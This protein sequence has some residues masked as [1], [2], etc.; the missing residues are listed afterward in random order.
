MN[1]G[2]NIECIIGTSIM[3]KNKEMVFELVNYIVLYK[4]KGNSSNSF[5]TIYKKKLK[6]L[7][8]LL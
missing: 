7:R 5:E 1:I 4:P 8:Y 2:I 3:C 6:I